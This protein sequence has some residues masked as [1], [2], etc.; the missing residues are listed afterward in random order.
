M[1]IRKNRI[2]HTSHNHYSIDRVGVAV[3]V[4]V[5]VGVGVVVV[6]IADE[7]EL[8]EELE[9]GAG[10]EEDGGGAT[11]LHVPKELRHPPEPAQVV[12]FPHWPL[13]ETINVPDGSGG[14]T[15]ELDGRID[16]LDGTTVELEAETTVE[17]D[18]GE[19]VG[20]GVGVGLGVSGGASPHRPYC[21]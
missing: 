10:T 12:I 6:P 7:V 19:G 16:E 4:G 17:L 9:I 1:S 13:G 20:V 5:G 11:P 18:D 8:D 14:K 3:D 15:D 2:S 21:G